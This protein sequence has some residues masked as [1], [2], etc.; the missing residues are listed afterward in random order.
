MALSIDLG[1]ATVDREVARWSKPP[2]KKLAYAGAIVE[3]RDP[4]FP[5]PAGIFQAHWFTGA[6][7]VRA[8]IPPERRPLLDPWF[9]SHCRGR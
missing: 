9:R 8:A 3:G 7:S 6:A 2:R 4:G 5:D 1:Y